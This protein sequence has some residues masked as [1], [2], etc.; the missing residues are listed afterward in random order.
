MKSQPD[1]EA[2]LKQ[3]ISEGA[4][5]I[6]A[7]TGVSIAASVDATTKRPHLQASWTGLL[8][9]GLK[10]LKDHKLIEEHV[11]DAHLTLLTN[12]PQTHNFISAAADVTARMG[13]AESDLFAEWLKRTVGSITA[14]DRSVLD[15][16]D[17]VRR[18]GNLLATT[19]YDGLLLEGNSQ[20]TP[21]TWLDTDV[22]LGA[23]RTRDVDNIVFLHGYWQKP[24]SVLLGW[25]SY[26]RNARNEEYRD[27][28]AA[29]WKTSIWVY[30]GCGVNGLSDPDFGL[31]LERYGPRARQARHWDYCLV[32]DNQRDEFQ[33]HFDSNEL[34][35]RAIPFG[36]DH[37]DLPKYLQSLVPAAVPPDTAVAPMPAH[38][39]AAPK[40][41]PMPTAP[42]FYAEPHYI[43]SHKFVGR[44]AELEQLSDWANPA[45]PTNLLL[46]ESIGGNG[47]SMV[48]WEWTKKHA[49]TVRSDWAGRF[50][51][52]FYER[53]AIMADFCQRA[54]A[55]MTGQPLEEF[56]KKKTAEL[57]PDL[58][59]QLHTKP[60][61]LILDGLERTLVA[62]HRIDAAELPD[63]E[64][65]APTDKIAN[66]NPCDAIRDE[67]NDLLRAF[68][69]ARPSKILISS[70]LT[71]RVLLN[72]SGQPIPGARRIDLPGLR[73]A[74]AEALL[75]SCGREEPTDPGIRGDSTA[76]QRFLTEYCDNHPLVIGAVS[77]LIHHYL[78]DRGNFDAWEADPDGGLQLDLAS[79]DLIQRRNHIL[80]AAIDALPPA[81]R[82]LLSTLALLSDSVDYETLEAFNPHRKEDLKALA[83]EKIIASPSKAR[84]E[85]AKTVR[86]LEIRGF[87]QFDRQTK[88]YD[89]HPVVRAVASGSQ[90][91]DEK[92]TLGRRVVDHFS[93]LRRNPWKKAES[94]EDLRP[95][96][97]V[98]RTLL[99]LG[100]FQQA[101][102]ALRGDLSTALL[103]NVEAYAECLSLLRPLFP[104]GWGKLPQSVDASDANYFANV[105]SMCLECMGESEEANSAQVASLWSNIE[106]E[107]WHN[108]NIDLLRF[109][110]SFTQQNLLAKA[111]RANAMSLE[112]S[113]VLHDQQQL[114][115]SRLALFAD[116]FNIGQWEEA[117]AT[118]KLLDPM[119]RGWSRSQYRP[120]TAEQCFAQ[121]QFWQGALQEAHLVAA[122]RLAVEGSN[123]RTLRGLHTLRGV[124]RLEQ[125]EWAPAAASLAEA[126]GMARA[127][128]IPDATSETGLALAKHHLGRLVGPQDEATRLAHLRHPAHRYL[129]MLCRAIGNHEQAKRHALAAYR[130]A[131]ADGE[132]YVNRYA[133]TK[134]TELLKELKLPIPN[135]PRYDSDKDEPFPWE[136]D[137]RAAIEKLRAEKEEQ[138]KAKKQK[139]N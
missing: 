4:A 53:G 50:W 73:P 7:G 118:W 84:K 16:L 18:R 104:A 115:L 66:R 68:S 39:S 15:A 135:L 131:W 28:L 70:R 109:S 88:Y 10:W 33:A 46:F 2:D 58:L 136:A 27:D 91:A 120:G 43:G 60:W 49:T 38:A 81:S 90:Q 14:H 106:R 137:I 67:D 9:D 96:L 98:V 110:S 89:L 54:L 5:V 128:G 72:T 124:W 105:A 116:Q 119:G 78:P 13:G 59:A 75:R 6:V 31:L 30:V 11:A 127:R 45:D 83:D 133:L 8:E 93:S 123:H 112:L 21:V 138:E 103:F 79:L 48:T 22:L 134:T 92:E 36:E 62:Y 126:V 42:A 125:G 139:P 114:F 12:N 100:D 129:A 132:P 80:R 29:F 65:N 44:K 108:L 55:Y 37:A 130:R 20:L 111:F 32:R 86:D 17:A 24:E 52:S 74:D 101:A 25:G 97:H 71:P 40:R 61:L 23:V 121:F 87:V 1:Y 69:A 122:D 47:K 94:L 56:A 117:T 19:N 77:G 3:T 113:T 34:N 64:A 102:K 41:S 95:G 35:I 26:D 51:Y 85:L 76:I 57:A 63:E 99:K 82:Q 107:S